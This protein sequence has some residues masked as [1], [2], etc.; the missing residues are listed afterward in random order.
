M[1]RHYAK[2]ETDAIAANTGLQSSRGAKV[3]DWCS[4]YEDQFP[5]TRL[6]EVFLNTAI[7][8]FDQSDIY[9]RVLRPD[10]VWVSS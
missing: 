1:L 8:W 4:Q 10:T 3:D 2:R 6:D 5:S 9:E 7:Y